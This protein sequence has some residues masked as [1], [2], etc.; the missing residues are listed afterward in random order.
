LLPSA[1]RLTQAYYNLQFSQSSVQMIHNDLSL[2]VPPL[3]AASANALPFRESLT[4]HN[5]VFRFP[6]AHAAALDGVTLTIPYGKSVGI[7]GGS[8]AGKSTAVDILLG[9]LEPSSGKVMVDG[10][11]IRTDLRGWQNLVGYVPQSIYL[12]DD[13]LRENI[14]FGVPP[15]RIDEEALKRAIKGAMLEEF[16]AALPNGAATVVGERGVRLSGGQRQRIGIAR[17][18]YH[19]PRVL[20]LDEATSALDSGTESEVMAAVN[21]LQGAKTIVIVAHRLSTLEHCDMLYRLEHGRLVQSGSF[22]EVVGT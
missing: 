19:D 5:V 2:P 13:S 22:A 17:A 20:V 4:L 6:N 12:C 8:G 16:V 3:S 11:D 10:V 21:A 15:E 18:L 7:L 9:L 14:A 1:N